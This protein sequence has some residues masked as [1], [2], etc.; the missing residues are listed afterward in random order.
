M[1]QEVRERPC[2]LK[3]MASRRAKARRMMPPA[4]LHNG[5]VMYT[6]N[7]RQTRQVTTCYN[8]IVREEEETRTGRLRMCDTR[9]WRC[10]AAERGN[11]GGTRVIP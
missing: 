10:C 11:L 5:G 6:V 2:V 3:V 1:W 7:E 8:W 4:K 9:Q